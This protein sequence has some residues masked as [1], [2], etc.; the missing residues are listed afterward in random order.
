MGLMGPLLDD[1]VNGAAVYE[2]EITPP[3]GMSKGVSVAL[4]T[5]RWV[6]GTG[7]RWCA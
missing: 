2:T 3:M 4:V 7:A 1:Y 5:L 6:Q